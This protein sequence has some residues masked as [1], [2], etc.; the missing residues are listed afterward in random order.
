M[1][2][3]PVDGGARMVATK[4]SGL[5]FQKKPEA[6]NLSAPK[7]HDSLRLWWRFYR[8]RKNRDFL[9][10]QGARFPLRR[11]SLANRDFF[12]DETGKND[13]R[14]GGP[15]DTLVCGKNR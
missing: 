3:S 2:D 13:P 10:P 6:N 7:S 5:F 8:S 9:R 4:G 12:C 15:C 1:N 14:C 11:K